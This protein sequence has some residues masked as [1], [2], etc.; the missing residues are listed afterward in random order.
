M[1][2]L[3]TNLEIVAR[4]AAAPDAAVLGGT[5]LDPEVIELVLIGR[6]VG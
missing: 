6:S 1:E 3:A 5:D 4:L 2:K